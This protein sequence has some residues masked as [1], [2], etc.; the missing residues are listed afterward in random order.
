MYVISYQFHF[1]ISTSHIIHA[2]IQRSIWKTGRSLSLFRKD[3]CAFMCLLQ[4][5]SVHAPKPFT[6][7][8]I[9]RFFYIPQPVQVIVRTSKSCNVNSDSCG[10]EQLYKLLHFLTYASKEEDSHFL[11]EYNR[12]LNKNFTFSLKKKKVLCFYDDYIVLL[13]S[14]TL[15]NQK[16]FF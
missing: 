15:F 6:L 14:H 8:F 16:Q 3:A 1:K 9:F 5:K 13:K 2:C 4:K 11:Q 10:H 12:K 7:Y